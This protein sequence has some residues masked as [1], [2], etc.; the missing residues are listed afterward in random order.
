VTSVR[1]IAASAFSDI[2]SSGGQA[3]QTVRVV[4]GTLL[5]FILYHLL[6]LPQGYWAVFTVVIVMQGSIGGTLGASIDRMKGTLFGAVVGGFAAWLRPQTPVGLGAALA[7]AVGVTAFFAASRPSLKVAP[8]TAVIMLISPSGGNLGPIDSA[9]FRVL[10]I[11]IGS[12]VGVVASVLIFPARSTALVVT[13]TRG[14]LTLMA[15]AL[16]G[17]ADTL[18]RPDSLTAHDDA[19]LRIRTA[20]AGIESA[21]VDAGRE[22]TSRLGEHLLSTALPRTLWRVRNDAISVSRALGPMSEG[23][24]ALI[25]QPTRALMQAE[26]DFMRACG[27]ALGEQRRVDRGEREAKLTAFEAAMGALRQSRLT[28][29][30]SFDAVGRLFGLGFALESLHRNLTDLGDRVDEAAKGAPL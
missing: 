6:N 22:H 19:Q 2:L 1:Q 4:A 15:D 8:V 14:A 18:D 16:E 26:A 7:F 11:A 12:V 17:Y 25:S 27:T 20:L 29:D 21:M 13:R 5:T 23:V 24:A 9:L 10:E 30:L 28:H 3:R